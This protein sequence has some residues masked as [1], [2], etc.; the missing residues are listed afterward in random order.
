[1]EDLYLQ[2]RNTK[3]NKGT[4]NGKRNRF[5]GKF[6]R[7]AGEIRSE[8]TWGWIRKD[9]LEKKTDGLT[10]AAQEQALKTNWIRRNFDGQEVSEKCR[11]CGERD[12]SITR[13]IAESQ[14]ACPKR[15]QKKT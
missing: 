9:Y 1:M 2:L 8:E 4:S 10:F 13:L 5:H 11:M 15:V 12:D 6:I 14:K 3:K 7:E